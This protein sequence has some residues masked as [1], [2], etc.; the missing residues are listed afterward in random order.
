MTLS[1][2]EDLLIDGSSTFLARIRLGTNEQRERIVANAGLSEKEKNLLIC[3]VDSNGQIRADFGDSKVYADS[4][5]PLA[6]GTEYSIAAW[7][8]LEDGTVNLQVNGGRVYSARSSKI[9]I[10]VV[11]GGRFRIGGWAAA[12]GSEWER[13]GEITGATLL[14]GVLSEKDRADFFAQGRGADR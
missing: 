7:S 1:N 2:R 11:P 14:N 6:A 12:S 9:R 4:E 10:P 8:N 13:E 5:G 3:M